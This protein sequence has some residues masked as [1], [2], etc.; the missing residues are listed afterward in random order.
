MG[1]RKRGD[2]KVK[3]EG[4][5][6][7]EEEDGRGRG[8]KCIQRRDMLIFCTFKLSVFIWVTKNTCLFLSS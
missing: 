2:R 7:E 6:T 3:G 1:R 8:E 5:R 4:E